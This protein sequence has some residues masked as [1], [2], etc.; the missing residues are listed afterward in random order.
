[1][2]AQHTPGPL[3]PIEVI[4]GG[5]TGFHQYIID[6]GGRKIGCCWGPAEEKMANAALWA[7]APE[8]AAECD[9]LRAVNAEL[10]TALKGLEEFAGQITGFTFPEGSRSPFETLASRCKTARAAITKAGQS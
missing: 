4:G 10:L 1:M 8:T 5:G 9:R 3:R 2:T 6:A 7:A